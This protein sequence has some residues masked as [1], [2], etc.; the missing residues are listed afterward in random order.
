[1]LGRPT[2][3]QLEAL[4]SQVEELA[5][6]YSMP[7]LPDSSWVHTEGLV[8]P[9]Y[10][11]RSDKVEI[12]LNDRSFWIVTVKSFDQVISPYRGTYTE[13]KGRSTQETEDDPL[14]TRYIR[15]GGRA[16]WVADMG[17]RTQSAR[18]AYKSDASELTRELRDFRST[19][20][21]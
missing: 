17:S 20:P 15:L 11:T 4:D 14:K 8:Y 7:P 16:L 13:F 3:E 10:G 21:A 5:R 12:Q 18:R 19:V 6:Q 1:M 2:T 9:T